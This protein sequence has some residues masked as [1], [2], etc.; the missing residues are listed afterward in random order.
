MSYE[1]RTGPRRGRG[2]RPNEAEAAK[3]VFS[4]VDF[5]VP[6][7]G[8]EGIG[9]SMTSSDDARHRELGRVLSFT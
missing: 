1:K 9:E 6:G 4:E 7:Q 5:C 8:K 3:K 2:T